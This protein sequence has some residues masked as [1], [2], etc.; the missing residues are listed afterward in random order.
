MNLTPEQYKQLAE[1]AGHKTY[2][3]GCL[4]PLEKTQEKGCMAGDCSMRPV[5]YPTHAEDVYIDAPLIGKRKYT[6]DTN[7]SQAFQLLRELLARVS[8]AMRYETMIDISRDFGDG[9][10][11]NLA[12]CHAVLALLENQE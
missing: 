7:D 1:F 3:G 11:L 9:E 8:R 12:I 5:P 2:C 4:W 6:P 10:S